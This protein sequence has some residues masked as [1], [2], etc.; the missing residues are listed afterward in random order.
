M[1]FLGNNRLFYTTI[2][3][4]TVKMNLNA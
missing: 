1:I 2:K 3:F 4:S